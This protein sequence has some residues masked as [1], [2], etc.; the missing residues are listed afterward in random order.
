[1]V[2]ACCQERG[3]GCLARSNLQDNYPG[4]ESTTLNM[5]NCLHVSRHNVHNAKSV[6]LLMLQTKTYDL[7]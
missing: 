3:S 2:P 6:Y 4:G 5:V 1:M 7:Y